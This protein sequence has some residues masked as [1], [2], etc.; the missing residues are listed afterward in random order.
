MI[1]LKKIFRAIFYTGAILVVTALITGIALKL[2]LAGETLAGPQYAGSN[3][4]GPVTLTSYYI[5]LV[6]LSALSLLMGYVF[7]K[8]VLDIFLENKKSP[9]FTAI[10][11]ITTLALLLAIAL[12]VVI[13]L[14]AI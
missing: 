8:Y 4:Y 9:M 11:L 14:P 12:A 6:V 1:D 3:Y 5:A 2:I 7:N 10:R 13:V